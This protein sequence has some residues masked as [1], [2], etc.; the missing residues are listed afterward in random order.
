MI[1]ML[2]NQKSCFGKATWTLHLVGELACK[3]N[4]LALLAAL[5]LLKCNLRL[6]WIGVGRASGSSPRGAHL[7]AGAAFF[8]LD[9]DRTAT[10]RASHPCARSRIAP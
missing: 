2:L 6:S 10:R 3:G 8:V 4:R 5:V 1:A 7:P 9:G